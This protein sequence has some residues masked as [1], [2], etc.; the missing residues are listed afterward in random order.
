MKVHFRTQNGRMLTLL[1]LFVFFGSQ[2]NCCEHDRIE[3]WHRRVTKCHANSIWQQQCCLRKCS[4]ATNA[5]SIVIIYDNLP[6]A[7]DINSQNTLLYR[8]DKIY[9]PY[10]EQTLHKSAFW[11]YFCASPATRENV[12]NRKRKFRNC[13]CPG[14]EL[15]SNK[16]N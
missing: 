4:G 8:F 2:P 13:A 12:I 9:S 7:V 16:G 1:E 10:D 6:N 14:K 3:K 11:S 5:H 15:G